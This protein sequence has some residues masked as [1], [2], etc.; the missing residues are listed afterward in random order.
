M[1]IFIEK[2]HS[3]HREHAVAP[4]ERALPLGAKTTVLESAMAGLPSLPCHSASVPSCE[5]LLNVSAIQLS[6]LKNGDELGILHRPVAV[7]KE[8]V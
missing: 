1:T 7:N 3:L 4:A 8:S 6:C 2:A 5:N